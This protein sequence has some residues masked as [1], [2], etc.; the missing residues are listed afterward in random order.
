[1]LTIPSTICAAPPLAGADVFELEYASK[2]LI[3]PDGK[4]ILY[5]HVVANEENDRFDKLLICYDVE[6]DLSRRILK[7]YD[8]TSTPTWSPDSKQFAI[9]ATPVSYTHLPSPRDRG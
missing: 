2:P 3:S 8:L 1:M 6:N 9:A 4:W 7:K 5:N